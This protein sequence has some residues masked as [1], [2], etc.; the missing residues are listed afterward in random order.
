MNRIL[1]I[2]RKEL[3]S[4]FR[5]HHTL[6]YSLLFPIILY[7]VTFWIM[8]QIMLLQQGDLEKQATRVA[9]QESSYDRLA[10]RLLEDSRFDLLPDLLGNPVP[11]AHALRDLDLDIVIHPLQC[12]PD[13]RLEVIYDQADE[14]SIEAK[15]RVDAVIDKI[16]E[17]LLIERSGM[18]LDSFPSFE[19]IPIDTAS[20]EKRSTFLI[21]A[22]LPM[23]IVIITLMGGLYPS[24]E[25]IVSERERNTL[26]T[27]LL[28][29][30][31]RTHLLAGKFIAV[32]LMSMLSVLLNVISIL[33]TLKH[34]LFMADEFQEMRFTLPL[35]SIPA[36]LFGSLLI[37]IIFNA[38]MVFLASFA[39]NFKEGQSY[40][41]LVYMLG[42]QPAVV[43]ALPGT[44]FTPTTALIP[45][46]NIALFFR[47]A[48]RG[49]LT[50]I[51]SVITLSM[52]TVLA[53]AF[54]LAARLFIS[55]ETFV[56]RPEKETTKK[57][58]AI[59]IP[60]R[61]MRR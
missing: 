55:R 24:I 10:I 8:N 6:L 1:T 60:W 35:H 29:P 12:M 5:D 38:L 23:I 22:I 43:A 39:R 49:E 20:V 31:S 19:M 14:R 9:F 58:R 50:L 57:K 2:V 54:L 18:R 11:D 7:P 36:I 3:L 46:T 56:Y 61:T 25:V 59:R 26:E 53:T 41:I 13:I 27:S 33:L 45:V 4:F 17:E 21:G 51:P 34:T 30:I 32:V 48:I 28:A 47:D 15:K 16:R 42:F 37:S 40:V 44:K 52:L